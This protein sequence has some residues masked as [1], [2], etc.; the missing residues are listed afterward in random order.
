MPAPALLWHDGR[1]VLKIAKDMEQR[2]GPAGRAGPHGRTP[3]A[4]SKEQQGLGWLVLAAVA[5]IVWLALPF[6]TGLL[7]GAVMAFMLEP[8]YRSL[9]RRRRRPSVA[10]FTIV[11][12]SGL[13]V[14]AALGGFLIMFITR[15]AAFAQTVSRQL[16]A[17]SY[18]GRVDMVMRWLGH[19][20][21]S[22]ANLRAHLEAGAGE[23]ASRSAALA[24]SLASDTFTGLLSL[25][26]ALLAM[27]AVLRH[28]SRMVST[29]ERIS[30]LQRSYTR[31]LLAEFR[32]VGRLTISGT[33]VTALAQGTIAALGFW[34]T[35]VPD[36][37]F[38]G[39]ATAI[40][41]LIP[42][43]GTLLV[44]VPA[45]VYLILIGHSGRAIME[46]V[47]G[48]VMVVGLSD[49]VIRPRLVG[50]R[51]VPPLLV[52]LA[53]F[54]GV[55]VMGLAGLIVGPVVMQLAIAVLRLY[56]RENRGRQAAP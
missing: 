47:W 30:P 55:Y 23:I 28:R 38:F 1:A 7:L 53:L 41:S 24:A 15:T 6:A 25:L 19:L 45:G 5:A 13:L 9:V 44:W 31:A 39:L 29:V 54:G 10:A 22:A 56:L 50:D 18:S 46:F 51:A 8:L 40:A 42:A 26:F 49:Y 21:I 52:F 4:R 3:I 27:Y 33:V 16:S 17:G 20:G 34:I 12:L 36:A 32:R 43:V 14:I 35:G 2:T 37:L 11:L 48:A